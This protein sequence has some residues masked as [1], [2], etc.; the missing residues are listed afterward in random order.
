MIGLE[1]LFPVQDIG[2]LPKAPWLLSYL[3]GKPVAQADLDHLEKWSGISGFEAKTEVLSTLAE[4][5]TSE[6]ERRIRDLASLFGIRFLES[7]GLDYVYDGEANRIEM[8]EHPIRHSQGF[9]FYGHVRS[10]DDRY[11]RK[12][13]CV[14]KVS[15]RTPYH[16]NEFN[17]VSKHARKRIKVPVTG[18]YTLAEWSFNEFYQKKLM[19]TRIF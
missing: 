7:A 3:R 4:P 18:A 16:L 11:Y 9:E 1:K 10:F 19:K 8:Y 17:Y 5:R 14:E 15:F 12:A 2:S 6:S 13:A